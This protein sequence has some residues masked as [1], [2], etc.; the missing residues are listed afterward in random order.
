MGGGGAVMEAADPSLSF[1]F[2]KIRSV[3]TSRL[4]MISDMA[5]IEDLGL[6]VDYQITGQWDGSFPR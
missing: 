5:D 1:I 6:S 4:D 2:G 3:R